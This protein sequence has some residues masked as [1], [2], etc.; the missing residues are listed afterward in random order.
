MN[1][2]NFIVILIGIIAS[3]GAEVSAQSEPR[4]RRAYIEVGSA[5]SDDP[6]NIPMPEGYLEP[7]TSYILVGGRVFDGTGLAARKATV[8]VKGR[9]IAAI[10]PPESRDW[11]EGAETIDVSGQT[12]MPGLIDMHVHMSYREDGSHDSEA[13]AT[14]R[15]IERL[16]FYAESGITTVRDVASEGM[17]PFRVKAWVGQHRLPLPRVYA[18]GQL[19]VGTGGHGDENNALGG[20]IRSASGA[21]DWREAVREQFKN[22]A[23]LIKIASHFTEEEVRAAV[24]E[25]HELGL[26]VT[27]DAETF[28]IER[29]IKAGVDIV[30]HPLPRSPETI[31]LMARLEV[32]SVPTLTTYNRIFDEAGGYWG[33]TSRRFSFSKEA[34]RTMLKN[35][36]QKGIKIGVGTDLVVDWFRA[37]PAPY[38]AELEELVGAGF[39]PSEALMAA[40][41]TNA[42]ILDM[43]EKLGTLEPGKLADIIVVN[44]RPDENLRDL[45]KVSIVIRDGDVIVKNGHSFTP[46]HVP[47]DPESWL[48]KEHNK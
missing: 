26:K 46:P 45:S 23:D 16:R 37:L 44:G 7:D 40:T 14:L 15:A 20:M 31:A 25:A 18:A 13:D 5:T 22:G 30:E 47:I 38:I 3:V 27:A 10:L 41:K 34:N 6:R 9:T 35:L 4:D 2:S 21:D 17:V 42:E 33:S 8:V 11:P 1:Y 43:G 39:T 48:S 36:K 29:A 12:V 19:I 28:Y 24:S 32:E